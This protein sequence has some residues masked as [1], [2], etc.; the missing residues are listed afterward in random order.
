MRYMKVSVQVSVEGAAKVER[1][2]VEFYESGESDAI[3]KVEVDRFGNLQKLS[4]DKLG[5]EGF[6]PMFEQFISRARL[7]MTRMF[8]RHHHGNQNGKSMLLI[9]GDHAAAD[10]ATGVLFRFFAAD[11]ELKHEELLTAETDLERKKRRKLQAQKRIEVALVAKRRGVQPPVICE[12]D[13]REFMDRLCKS[14]IKL[15]W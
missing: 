12:T 15:G 2:I 11:G 7:D 6:A 5:F 1:H 14:Y 3:Y 10:A 4:I 9:A 8:D 13:D